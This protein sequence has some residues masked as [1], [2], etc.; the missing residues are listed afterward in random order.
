[1]LPLAVALFLCQTGFHGFIASL[2]LALAAA[3]SSDAS[4]GVLMG[5]AAV[6]QIGAAFVAG[7]LIDR[8][9]GERVFLLGSIA[10]AA[11]AALITTGFAA[12]GG[13]IVPLV[14]VRLLQGIG[15]AAVQPAVFSLVPTMVTP[16]RLATSLAF[17]GVAANISLAV[18]PPVSLAVLERGSLQAVG[19]VTLVATVAGAILLL[20][21][22]H[23]GR[24]PRRSAEAAE[25][26]ARRGWRPAWRASWAAPLAMSL[27]FIAHWG[28]VTAYLPV[29]A[30]SAGAD[31]GLFFTADALALLSL[32]VVGGYLADRVGSRALIVS[33]I[34]VTLVAL[35]LLLLPPTTPLLIVA[36]IGSGTG[37]ALIIPPIM[38]E[39]TRRSGDT[40]RGS[41]FALFSVAFSMGIAVGSLGV[42]PIIS[43]IG[44]ETALAVGMVACLAAGILCFMDRSFS[45]AE[46]AAA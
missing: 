14:I 46:V 7:G 29:R 36:G 18:S 17:V 4:I 45:R 2:P 28:V 35:S 37:G 31:V 5:L 27:L 43:A 25:A 8:F 44:F 34:G 32:R 20:L 11:A 21:I 3:G 22:R 19:A 39:L 6:M 12:P 40:D 26:S 13:W 23:A 1:M 41:A 10:F 16:A 33:G 15:L 24:I 38:L 42:A 9:G 30:A